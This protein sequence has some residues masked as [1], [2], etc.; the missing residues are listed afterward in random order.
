MSQAIAV[1]ICTWNR[2][3][4]LAESL[5][6]LARV[7]P[8]VGTLV[9][10]LVVD[11]NSKDDT[12]AT[13]KAL[14]GGWPLG[15]LHA[16]SEPRQGKQ[17]ALN[18]GIARARE[19][20]C[21]WL[22]F[23][24]DDIVFPPDWLE[25]ADAALSPGEVMLIGGRTELLWPN[26]GP[27]A[28]YHDTMSA[29]VGGIDL[30]PQRLQPP[31]P[32]YAPAGA[33]LV[34][35]AELFERVGGF[36]ETHFRHMDFEFGQRCLERGEVVAYEPRLVV[37]APVEAAILTHRYFRR[38]SFKAGISPWQ[39]MDTR[40][41]HFAWVPLW[42]YRQLAQDALQWMVAPLRG[43]SAAARFA[44]ELRLYRAWGTISS[45]WMSRLRPAA[46]PAWVERRSQKRLNVY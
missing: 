33:N 2:A 21:N 26:G 24:D 11:N 16:L 14:Q 39:Q 12:Q 34:A 5:A 31:P 38:W 46:Y 10:V 40:V 45:R 20:G 25:Q 44:R 22:A 37:T 30:G 41:R 6:S 15:R 43:D 35:R 27:P 29:V 32:T 13:L 1:I 8:P 3:A 17:F 19:L 28:W 18:T 42:L 9:E 7:R 23:S 4:V 36:A